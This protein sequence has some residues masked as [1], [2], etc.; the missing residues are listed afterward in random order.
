MNRTQLI[1]LFSALG[2][3]V[4]PHIK[5]LPPSLYIFFYVLWGWRMLGLWHPQLLP[6]K[7]VTLLCAVIAVAIMV[8]LKLGILGR[9][10]GTAIFVSAVGLKLLEIKSPRDVYLLVC[11]TFISACTLFLYQQTIF[12]A[13]YIILTSS[14]LLATLVLSTSPGLSPLRASRTSV[15]LL[16]Q[17]LPLTAIMFL[18]FPRLDAPRWLW[19]EENNSAISGLSESMTP[20]EISRLGMSDELAFRVKFEGEI[21]PQQQLYWRGPVLSL[22]DGKQWQ[23]QKPQYT[24]ISTRSIKYF[25]KAYRYQILL[26]PQRLNYV[27]ALE[28]AS[29]YPSTLRMN[30]NFQL[31]SSNKT[32]QYQEFSLASHSHFYIDHLTEKDRQTNLQLP[33]QPSAKINTLVQQLGGFE[34][35]HNQFARNV[36]NY[37]TRHNFQYTLTPPLM[38]Q[39]PIE[40]FLFDHRAGFC[41]HYATA[42]VYLMRVAGIPARVITGYQGGELNDVGGFLEVRQANA[43]AWTEIWLDNKGWMRIDPTATVAPERIEQNVNV[44]QQIASGN[45]SFTH[46]NSLQSVNWLRQMHRLWS[47][48]DYSWQRWVINYDSD[49]QAILLDILSLFN[50]H[51]LLHALFIFAAFLASLTAFFLLRP[52]IRAKKD[53]AQH[54][55]DKFCHKIYHLTRLQ[56]HASEGPV[57]FARRVNTDFPDLETDVSSIT[58]LYIKIRYQPEHDKNDML[59]LKHRIR[60]FTQRRSHPPASS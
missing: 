51:N 32:N 34:G 7:I 18:F 27:Y 57:N 15:N 23:Q 2:L 48:L 59:S 14:S 38:H 19:F 36:L 40:Q 8:Y 31:V 21:P 53:Q 54:L 16:L 4:L 17:A 49:N 43:H 42:F 24:H 1:F 6:N 33:T 44:D 35:H 30:S 29:E 55:Y 41:S 39:R 12:M 25:G 58:E 52:S 28:R 11:L 3:I 37:F 20:G 5:N 46:I 50:I 13:A 47:S 9:D 10:P 45:V 26:E 56:K 60:T 22:T